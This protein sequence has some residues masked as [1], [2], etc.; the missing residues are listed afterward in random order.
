MKY[1]NAEEFKRLQGLDSDGSVDAIVDEGLALRKFGIVTIDDGGHEEKADD[2]TDGFTIPFTISTVA[3]DRDG[4]TINPKGWDL[5]EYKKNPVVLWAHDPRQPPIARAEKTFIDRERN[6]LRSEAAFPPADLY[7]FGNMV[8][9]M[10]RRKFLNAVSVGFRPTEFKLSDDGERQ[11]QFPTDFKRQTLLE[12]SGVPIPSNP[13]ALIEARGV[14]DLSPMIEWAEKILDGEGALV[15]PRSTMESVWKHARGD[16]VIVVIKS[17]GAVEPIDTVDDA[18]PSTEDTS[19]EAAPVI[20]ASDES[21][22]VDSTVA[23]DNAEP[24][25]TGI[26]SRNASMTRDKVR[27]VV[28]AAVRSEIAAL[29]AATKGRSTE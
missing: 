20:S 7:P 22:D 17:G 8:G 21:R 27:E 18:T 3:V 6:T 9:R 4:D 14:M 5:K 23:V 2:Q 26:E 19:D 13:E 28:T 25:D 12:Y 15:V 11:G 16:R 24:L 1:L 10:F 29:I